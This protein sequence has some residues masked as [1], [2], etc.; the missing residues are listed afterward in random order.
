L[1]AVT[2]YLYAVPFV[3]PLMLQLVAGA[4][5]VQVKGPG[6]GLPEASSAVTVY[7]VAV[8]ADGA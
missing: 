4:V 3:R 2:E 6:T 7:E 1:F 8:P 5:T